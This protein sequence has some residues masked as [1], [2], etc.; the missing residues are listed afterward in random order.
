MNIEHVKLAPGNVFFEV[1]AVCLG[2]GVPLRYA[3][4]YANLDGPTRRSFCCERCVGWFLPRVGRSQS[5]AAFRDSLEVLFSQRDSPS[6]M[7]ASR[8][9]VAEHLARP[10]REHL[11]IRQGRQLAVRVNPPANVSNVRLA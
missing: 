3:E 8:P 5:A 9:R 11:P 1:D 7:N 10:E 2:C 6:V 4:G